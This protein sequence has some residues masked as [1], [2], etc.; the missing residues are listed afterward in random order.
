MLNK[1]KIF[2]T[3][4]LQS[5]GTLIIRKMSKQH[6]SRLPSHSEDWQLAGA[7]LLLLPRRGTTGSLEIQSQGNCPLAPLSA[8]GPIPAGLQPGDPTPE[9]MQNHAVI[10]DGALYIIAH[11]CHSQKAHLKDKHIAKNNLVSLKLS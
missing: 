2:T 9:L 4:T 1:S 11:P 6:F 5:A 8:K 3:E 7:R 10:T